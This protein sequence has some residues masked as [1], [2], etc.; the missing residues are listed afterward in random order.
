MGRE[1]K[2]PEQKPQT[3]DGQSLLDMARDKID[4][5]LGG[6]TDGEASDEKRAD[7]DEWKTNPVTGQPRNP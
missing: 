2:Q 1:P 6:S 7:Y 5:V 3:G 4:D